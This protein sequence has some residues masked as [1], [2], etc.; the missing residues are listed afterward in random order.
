MKDARR[1]HSHHCLN[2]SLRESVP[3][4]ELGKNTRVGTAD[5]HVSRSRNANH[6]YQLEHEIIYN[7]SIGL[8][9]NKKSVNSRVQSPT[10]GRNSFEGM[11]NNTDMWR[12]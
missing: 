5:R 10:R 8:E 1:H 4:F 12:N 11:H 9:T 7:G 3:V 6:S 2:R